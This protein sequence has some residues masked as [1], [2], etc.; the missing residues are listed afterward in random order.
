MR[1]FLFVLVLIFAMPVVS[2]TRVAAQDRNEPL[3]ELLP[4]LYAEVISAE[5]RA[6]ASQLP[7]LGID[8]DVVDL[9]DRAVER[10]L[11]DTTPI[12]TL[13]GNQLSSFPLASASGGFSWTLDTA[14]GVFT[15][16]SN[17]F[18]PIFAERPMTIG[19]GRLNV[20]ATFQHVSFD[21]LEDR[22]LQGGEIVSYLSVPL[23]NA[24][25]V[26]FAN[27]LD[28]KVT[29]DT[30]NMFATFGVTDRF[31]VGVAVPINRVDARA[32]LS[33][34][35]GNTRDGVSQDESI[36]FSA[37]GRESGIGDVVIRQ[38]FNIFRSDDWGV[39]QSIDVRLP[40]GDELNLLGV[41]GPQFKL[42]FIGSSTVGKLSPH[43]NLAYTISGSTEDAE[44]PMTFII[45]PPEEFNYA[46]G[47]DM[48]LSL[49]A[50]VA[51]DV[52]GRVMR[53]VGTLAWAPSDFGG[54]AYSQFDFDPEGNLHLMLG[55]V[56]LKVNPF[57]NMLL[58][59]NVLFPLK[60]TGLTDKLTW[61]AGVDYSF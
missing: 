59:T 44:N 48:A 39:A 46:A 12:I 50:T 18:G 53:G 31:D 45:E 55:S 56:G 3:S 17:S 41:G 21:Q 52:V 19:R 61:M 14:S 47:A 35:G 13:A 30:V 6:F 8:V 20:G 23:P 4:N 51:A 9:I 54:A 40:T 38:K 2:P 49:R 15:R 43:L 22:K 60:K 11:D 10:Y 24:E 7:V 26:F 57:G 27:E 5:I 1:R 37:S 34:L 42:T 32:T 33:V 58:T 29:A 28:L 25:H 16:T 36:P